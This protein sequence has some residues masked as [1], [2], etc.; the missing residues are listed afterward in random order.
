MANDPVQNN[1]PS[2]HA[3]NVIAVR[4][5]QGRTLIAQPPPSSM[6]ADTTSRVRDRAATLVNMDPDSGELTRL[7]HPAP[8]T[9]PLTAA[10]KP[11]GS[12]VS[13][14]WA[15][16]ASL[17]SKL[18]NTSLTPIFSCTTQTLV[19]RWGSSPTSWA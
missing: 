16:Q 4:Q 1:N 7:F 14:L 8:I 5:K 19:I 18:E 9:G 12:S 6:D 10:S 15:E 13:Y 11:G 2:T 3:M 17:S